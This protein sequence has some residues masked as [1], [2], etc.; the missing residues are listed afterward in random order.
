MM[1]IAVLSPDCVR[2]KYGPERYHVFGFPR[3]DS[4]FQ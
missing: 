1:S 2:N 3:S 4:G